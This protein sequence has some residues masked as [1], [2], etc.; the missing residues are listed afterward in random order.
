MPEESTRRVLKSFGIAVTTLEE[1]LDSAATP[2]DVKTAASELRAQLAAI[3]ALV[4]RLSER[5]AR[6]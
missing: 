2:A 3:N 4:E 5:A 6:V 1:A